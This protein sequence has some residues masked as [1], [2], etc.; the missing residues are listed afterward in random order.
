[1]FNVFIICLKHRSREFLYDP[2]TVVWRVCKIYIFACNKKTALNG[3][4]RQRANILY[5]YVYVSKCNW[6]RSHLFV[7][8][9]SIFIIILLN[10]I[11]F[12]FSSKLIILSDYHKKKYLEI[13]SSKRTNYVAANFFFQIQVREANQSL[14]LLYFYVDIES[15]PHWWHQHSVGV[16]AFRHRHTPSS[17]FAVEGGNYYTSMSI[18]LKRHM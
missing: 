10:L 4:S 18:T 6:N 8:F 9:F 11:H 15:I 17:H 12:Y 16:S 7:L 14:C 5:A 3:R 2:F 1:M 13:H